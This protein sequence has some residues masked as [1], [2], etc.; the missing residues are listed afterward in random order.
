MKAAWP[1]VN[2]DAL[3][4]A[5]SEIIVQING[6]LRAKVKVASNE[7]EE[8]LKEKVLADP[9]VQSHMQDKKI[10][11]MIVVPNRLVNIV[12]V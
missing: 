1:A 9:A 10:Q 11:R 7:S 12:V 6:K 4:T 8:A 5:E 3:T 2:T